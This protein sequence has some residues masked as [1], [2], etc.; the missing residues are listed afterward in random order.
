[1]RQVMGNVAAIS[2]GSLPGR[3][4][5]LGRRRRWSL[6]ELSRKNG[7]RCAEGGRGDGDLPLGG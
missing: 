2:L 5:G 3:R 4:C 7:F 1:M 6:D